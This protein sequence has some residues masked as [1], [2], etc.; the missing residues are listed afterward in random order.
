VATCVALETRWGDGE[1]D[2]DA[3]ASGWGESPGVG[4]DEWGVDM[5]SEDKPLG[6]S[7]DEREALEDRA[8]VEAGI[9]EGAE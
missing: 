2:G 6:V 5:G 8:L 9:P 4:Y 7:G 1:F 3:D